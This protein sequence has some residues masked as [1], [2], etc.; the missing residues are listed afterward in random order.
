MADDLNDLGGASLFPF[1]PTW[2][3]VPKTNPIMRRRVHAYRATVAEVQ[4][5][6]SRVPLVVRTGYL[7]WTRQLLYDLTDFWISHKGRSN[8]FWLKSPRNE[9][10]LMQTASF[11]AAALVVKSNSAHYNIQA[12]ERICIIM[13]NGDVL[14]H[15]ITDVSD[16]PNLELLTITIANSLDREIRTDNHVK[17]CRLLLVRFDKDQFDIPM[18]TDIMS[19]ISLDFR[20]L[21]AEYTDL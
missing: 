20:E 16:D 17:L 5:V 14:T 6:T 3:I 15:K 11:G 12:D 10:T 19:E 7:I 8:R 9:F 2:A 13:S 18:Y 21:P 1:E 4:Q